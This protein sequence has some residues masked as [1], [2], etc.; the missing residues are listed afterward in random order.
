MR[1]ISPSRTAPRQGFVLVVVMLAI[2]SIMLIFVAV[3][4]SRLTGL[5]KEIRLVEDKQI[6]RWNQLELTTT[7][8]P[9]VPASILTHP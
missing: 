4:G 8:A 9:V 7:N 2:A 6:R 1:M 5:K 3:N